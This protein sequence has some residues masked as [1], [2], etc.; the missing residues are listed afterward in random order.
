MER[1]T[2]YSQTVPKSSPRKTVLAVLGR[3]STTNPPYCGLRK[4]RI[5]AEMLACG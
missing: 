1:L 4:C 3:F 5:C 2:W